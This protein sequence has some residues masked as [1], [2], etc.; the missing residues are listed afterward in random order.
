MVE[1]AVALICVCFPCYWP[2]FRQWHGGVADSGPK[3]LEINAGPNINR[4]AVESI[5]GG[6]A[7]ERP[8]SF[9]QRSNRRMGL[10]DTGLSSTGDSAFMTSQQGTDIERETVI[11]V[12]IEQNNGMSVKEGSLQEKEVSRSGSAA[13]SSSKSESDIV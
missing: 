13:L 12:G 5:G 2:L 3:P 1:P 6:P 11:E 9:W 4:A 8:P 10:F 7:V